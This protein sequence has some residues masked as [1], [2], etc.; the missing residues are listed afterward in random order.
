M[1]RG[2]AEQ[3]IANLEEGKISAETAHDLAE[4]AIQQKAEDRS[5]SR[6]AP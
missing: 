5:K 6:P 4:L 1:K 2:C 3:L